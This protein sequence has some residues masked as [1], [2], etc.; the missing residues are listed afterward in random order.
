MKAKSTN[1]ALC[2]HQSAQMLFHDFVICVSA[3]YC[4]VQIWF[5]INKAILSLGC[6]N[7]LNYSLGVGYS[8]RSKFFF[9]KI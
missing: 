5:W 2:T 3:S 4:C 9:Q 6:A 8:P 1:E 7:L